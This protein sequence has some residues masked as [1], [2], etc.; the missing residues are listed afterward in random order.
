MERSICGLKT[1]M[2]AG[3]LSLVSGLSFLPILLL[4]VEKENYLVRFYLVQ[5]F[6]LFL[7]TYVLALV[8]CGLGSIVT[9][10]FWVIMVVNAFKGEKYMVPLLGGWAEKILEQD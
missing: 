8:T 6:L 2:A 4:F 10:I 1:N 3:L 5:G 9:M 7:A